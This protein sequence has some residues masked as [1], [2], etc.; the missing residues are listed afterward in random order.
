VS[1]V[2]CGYDLGVDYDQ[3]INDKVGNQPSDVRFCLVSFTEAGAKYLYE[4][5]Y[6]DRGRMEQMIKDHKTALKSD[7]TSCHRKEANSFKLFIQSA[8][9]V[10]MHALRARKLI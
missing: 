1:L 9:Y 3:I 6:C 4:A 10:L 8:A 2:E 7:R 5:V